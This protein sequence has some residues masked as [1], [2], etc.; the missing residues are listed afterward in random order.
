MARRH[1]GRSRTAVVVFGLLLAYATA[2]ESVAGPNPR[3]AGSPTSANAKA[4]TILGSAWKAD[5]SPIPNA[6]VRLRNVVTGR[7]EAMDI[8]DAGGQFTFQ[9]AEPGSYL[10]ELLNDDGRVIAIG[11]V[12]SIAAG[13]TVATFVRLSERRRLGGFFFNAAATALTAASGLG[14]TA[15]GSNG[16][17]VSAAPRSGQ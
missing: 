5:N 11:Q 12:F 13:E 10:V 14:L 1:P 6:K 4:G 15:L 8:A 7:A 2:S 17:P 9:N 3:R 16:Q